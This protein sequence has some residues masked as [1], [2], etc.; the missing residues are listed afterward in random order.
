MKLE[1][2]LAE[3]EARLRSG[4]HPGRARRDAET[5]LL[6]VLRMER[7]ALLVRWKEVLD[8]AESERYLELI[9]RRQA[10]EPIQYIRGETEFYGLPFYVTRDC[11]IPRPETE[12]LA[13]KAIELA[14]RFP[15]PR[16][17]D[18][19]TGSGCIAVALAAHLPRAWVAAT[20]LSASALALARR[21][22]GRHA[23]A[24]R[25][26]FL[27]GNLLAPAAGEP[28][29]LVVSNPPYVPT[30]DRASLAVEVRDFEPPLALFAGPDG[31][32]VYR[33]LIPQA[34]A[35]LIPGGFVVL[36]IGCGQ[37]DAVGG[38][39][40][41]AGFMGIEFTPDLQGIPRVAAARR[42]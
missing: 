29:D 8:E 27:K 41:A 10:G 22:A 32:E 20:D 18:V 36:E 11:L 5:L 14:G 7:A 38:L 25:I 35:A 26:R 30:A 39:L 4:P 1:Q 6:D 42:P 23:V 33:A 31:L 40:T 21:N 17:A 16:I 34:F 13:E 15:A 37:A 9:A 28:F 24:G 3:G 2:W 12:H 19:G